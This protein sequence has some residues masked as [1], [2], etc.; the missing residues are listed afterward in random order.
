[1]LFHFQIEL[2]DMDRSVYQ[3][4]DFRTAQHPSES[5]PCVISRVLAFALCYQEGL[6]FSPGGLNDPEAPALRLIGDHGNIDLWIEVGNPSTRKLHKASKAAKQVTI[7]TY[8]N[9]G[10]ELLL[11]DIKANDVHRANDL[12]IYSFEPKFLQ[13]LE[14]Y[15]QKNNKWSLLHQ[16]GHLDVGIADQ[17]VSS[18]L[19][20]HVAV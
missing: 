12:K 13:S 10:A 1:M 7:F 18:N 5:T 3:T 15:L 6:E 16:D 2:S 9:S 8:K 11:A 20:A 4:L 19:H 14:G 17:L